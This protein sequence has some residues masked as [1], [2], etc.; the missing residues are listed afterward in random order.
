[1]TQQPELNSKLR[2]TSH[3]DYGW[4]VILLL[5]IA[6][7]MLDN[8]WMYTSVGYIDAW[9][10]QP[11]FRHFPDLLRAF[12]DAYF[13]TRLPW[14]IPGFVLHQLFPPVTAHFILHLGVY[15]LALGAFYKLLKLLFDNRAALLT[16]IAMGCYAYF[17]NFTGWDDVYGIIIGYLILAMLLLA[18]AAR[19]RSWQFFL[20]AAGAAFAG[21]VFANIFSLLFLPFLAGFYYFDSSRQQQRNVI[22]SGLWWIAGTATITLLLC[23]INYAINLT[24]LS[25]SVSCFSYLLS[26]LHRPDFHVAT[27]YLHRIT[28]CGVL[29][30]LHCPLHW[31]LLAGSACSLINLK[32]SVATC[33][34]SL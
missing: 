2:L 27:I 5:P 21:A 25:I 14:I 12:P 13:G 3:F 34:S 1:L 19:S 28:G 17:L 9:L 33:S 30:G 32:P 18:L 16:S 10:Y 29:R 7:L 8:R 15:Y 22:I 4:L 26:V 24:M 31:Q 11:Y 23:L 20:F 6:I